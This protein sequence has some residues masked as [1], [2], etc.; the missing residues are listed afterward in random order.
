[1]L[2][3]SPLIQVAVRWGLRAL[4]QC[5]GVNIN[6]LAVTNAL[7]IALINCY[8]LSEPTGSD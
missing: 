5:I 2:V 6:T 3:G 7:V 4:V 1:V 8:K